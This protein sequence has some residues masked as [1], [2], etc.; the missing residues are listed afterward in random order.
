[1]DGATPPGGAAHWTKIPLRLAATLV[2]A[3]WSHP[4]QSAPGRHAAGRFCR[5]DLPPDESPPP[6]L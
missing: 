5:G 3:T 1:V 6:R 4:G 2:E